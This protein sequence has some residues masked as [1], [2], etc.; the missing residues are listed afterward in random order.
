MNGVIGSTFLYVNTPN[1]ILKS[2]LSSLQ[3]W[4][5]MVLDFERGTGETR[6]AVVD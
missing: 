5:L 6:V 2:G 4:L 3:K 1:Q